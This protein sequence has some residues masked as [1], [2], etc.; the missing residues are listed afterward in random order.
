M[1]TFQL[2][3][4]DVKHIKSGVISTLHSSGV[5]GKLREVSSSKAAAANSAAIG[6]RDSIPSGYKKT[7]PALDAEN[8]NA[9]T[10]FS[11]D[12]YGYEIVSGRYTAYSRI[13][14]TDTEGEYDQNQHH[15]L[16]S[17]NH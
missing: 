3:F 11:S 4:H 5:V 9:S 2:K 16:D 7:M 6:R 10:S 12:P 17:L 8:G 13:G 1:S 14:P 15:T